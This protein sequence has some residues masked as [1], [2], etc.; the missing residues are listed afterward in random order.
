MMV[1][2]EPLEPVMSILP[3]PSGGRS[4]YHLAAHNNGLNDVTWT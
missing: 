3:I 4:F 1:V 2:L